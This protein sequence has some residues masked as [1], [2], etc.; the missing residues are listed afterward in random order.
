MKGIWKI[1]ERNTIFPKSFNE[2]Y[3]KKEEKEEADGG[4]E[5]EEG[6]SVTATTRRRWLSPAIRRSPATSSGLPLSGAAPSSD[7]DAEEM[8]KRESKE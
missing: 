8:K 6:P 5:E 4:K 3:E 1:G 7:V 2:V